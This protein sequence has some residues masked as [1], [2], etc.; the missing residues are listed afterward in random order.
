M[1]KLTNQKQLK[2]TSRNSKVT[3]WQ[4]P[5]RLKWKIH[6]LHNSRKM[7]SL[8]VSFT[9]NHLILVVFSQHFH[10]LVL[11]KRNSLVRMSVLFDDNAYCKPLTILYVVEVC[12]LIFSSYSTLYSHL[13]CTK[14]FCSK[15]VW[16][17]G[18]TSVV[19]SLPYKNVR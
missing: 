19:H 17:F 13:E 2:N 11:V 15:S 16:Y 9:L 18:H 8:R 3:K 1:W 12:R 10:A 6:G 5:M 4:Q 7:L 14:I